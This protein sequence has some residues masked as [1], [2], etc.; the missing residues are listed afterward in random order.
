MLLSKD[1]LFKKREDNFLKWKKAAVAIHK[2]RFDYSK[3]NEHFQS[4]K[5]PE[6][7]I[8]CNAH[9]IVFNVSPFNHLRSKSGGCKKCDYEIASNAFLAKE[10]KKFNKWFLDNRSSQYEI[11]SKFNGMTKDIHIL[12]KNHKTIKK[13]K[14]TVIM[15]SVYACNACQYESLSINKR[16][17]K[18]D[19]ENELNQILPEHIRF[20]DL[21]FDKNKKTT[22]ISIHCAVHGNLDVDLA[23]LRNSAHK[24]PKCGRDECGYTSTKLKKLLDR[25]EIGKPTFL[26]VMEIE[27]FGIRTLKVGISTRSLEQ[28]YA[29][30]LKTIFF[31]MQLPEVD[32]YIME[33]DIHKKFDKHHDKR[34]VLQGMRNGARWAGDTECYW[35]D[36][37][38]EIIDYIKNILPKIQ[39]G[40]LKT[41][42][43]YEFYQIPDFYQRDRTRPKD[44][45]KKPIAIIGVDPLTNKIVERFETITAAT[46]AGY[47]NISQV[48]SENSP[49]QRSGGLRWF[50]EGAFNPES[51]PEM[52]RH[53][54]AVPVLCIELNE[55]F[56]S[57]MKAQTALRARGI[58]ISASHI[59]SVCKGVRSKA[60]G[61]TWKYAE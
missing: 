1:A 52:K 38:D 50:H 57:T 26:G 2:E 17:N 39:A 11:A 40:T 37:K 29:W 9:N 32:A 18:N 33:N 30:H 20:I 23:Y 41:R 58:A 35:L 13:A 6:I 19:V 25:N 27:V 59:T 43:E 36:K 10:E 42:K 51:I 34:L 12:C 47:R 4:Q 46:A 55:V 49:R 31:S 56:D 53:G 14:P 7:I 21:R 24:C 16:L 3:S 44:E 22:K 48:L 60:G 15:S 28:R 8:K 54:H 61:Y 45:S 5:T